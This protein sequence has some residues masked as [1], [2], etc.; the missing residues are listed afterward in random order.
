MLKIFK[1]K[2]TQSFMNID[3]VN[4]D[5]GR[6][7]KL[8]NKLNSSA[9]MKISEDSIHIEFKNDYIF[10]RE[11]YKLNTIELLLSIDDNKINNIEIFISNKED[12]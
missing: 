1:S 4:L 3:T 12:N 6:L 8:I 5:Y 7:I 2:C 10:I 9:N 11:T